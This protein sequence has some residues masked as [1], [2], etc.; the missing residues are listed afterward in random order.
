[1]VLTS[2]NN[3]PNVDKL[4]NNKIEHLEKKR[5]NMWNKFI[6]LIPDKLVDP[7]YLYFWII[8]VTV[9][10]STI[11]FST[12]VSIKYPIDTPNDVLQ[13]QRIEELERRIEALE[14][15]KR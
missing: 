7:N 10:I 11:S 15:G 4:Q 1:M 9:T 12:Y 8:V 6:N 3:V 5:L 2:I 14:H 13:N